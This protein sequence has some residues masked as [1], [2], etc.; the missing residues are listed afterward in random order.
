[1]GS[2]LPIVRAMLRTTTVS[3]GGL[4]ELRGAAYATFS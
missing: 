1:M 2:D 3:L 4:I